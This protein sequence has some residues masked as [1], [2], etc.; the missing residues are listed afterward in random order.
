[1]KKIRRSEVTAVF[2]SD[3]QAVWNIVTNNE[4]YKWRSDIDRVE[5]INDG[6]G[7]IEHTSK[8][9]ATKFTITCKE[10]FHK[11][12][13]DMENK[14]FTGFWS[15]TF[16][17]TETGGTKVVFQENIFIKNFVVSF[18]SY[19]I[20]DLKKMQNQYISDLRAKLGE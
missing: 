13:F 8:G 10:E 15:G 16:S 2:N 5:I 14:L 12:G 9:H 4:D 3:I 6:T 19:F 20:M 1:M 11:Y 7:F 18:L 17:V